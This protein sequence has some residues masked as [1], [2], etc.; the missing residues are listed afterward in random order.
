MCS[1]LEVYRNW[2]TDF[3]SDCIFISEWM[4]E[5]KIQKGG[6]EFLWIFYKAK[7]IG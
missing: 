7:I 6:K 5:K 1:K 2:L 3:Y 4:I